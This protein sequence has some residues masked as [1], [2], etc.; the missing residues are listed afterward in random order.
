MVLK[1][2]V[3]AV[4]LL[5]P[6]SAGAVSD[7]PPAPA[8]YKLPTMQE[9]GLDY[10]AR[11]APFVEAPVIDAEAVFERVAA[12]YPAESLYKLDVTLKGMLASSD[13]AT[14]EDNTNYLGKSYVGLV[15]SVPVYSGSEMARIKD[16]EYNRR[17]EIAK[18]ISDLV[19]AISTRN[20]AHRETALYSSLEARASVRVQ[21]GISE[22]DEQVKYLEKVA[23][24]HEKAIVQE[25]K[26]LEARLKLAGTCRPEVAPEIGKW[27]REICT[28]DSHIPS[29]TP[30]G[31]NDQAAN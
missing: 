3:L 19:G 9:D 4:A 24:A 7:A 11:P 2:L 30:G 28:L 26:I 5:D 12:C 25:A 22:L 13:M 17:Q 6:I 31:K 23:A 10:H 16:R 29:G 27:L 20:Q 15:A 14:I 18:T 1:L 8:P 21:S